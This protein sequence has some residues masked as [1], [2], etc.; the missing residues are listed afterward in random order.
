MTSIRVIIYKTLKSVYVN[1]LLNKIKSLMFF[2]D[3]KNFTENPKQPRSQND[4]D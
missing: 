3:K 4:F 2:S 1:Q